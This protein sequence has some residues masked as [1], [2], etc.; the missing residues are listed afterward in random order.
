MNRVYALLALASLLAAP[1]ITRAD[2]NTALE[3]HVF[4]QPT[5]A[6]IAGARV[7]IASPSE[8]YIATTDV[9]GRFVFFGVLSDEYRIT[10]AK[11]GYQDGF[12]RSFTVNAG[13]T[14]Y[15]VMPMQSN[16]A[17]AMLGYVVRNEP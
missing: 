1:A 8:V 2:S 5:G 14:D 13:S 10:V 16:I 7:Y 17:D 9:R 15:V 4:D 3:G 11:Q 12:A 6:A